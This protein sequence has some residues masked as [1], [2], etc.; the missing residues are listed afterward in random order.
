[1]RSLCLITSR[2]L[3]LQRAAWSQRRNLLTLAIETSCDDTS[4]AVLE[5]HNHKSELH[6]HSRITSDSRAFQGVHPIIALKSHQKNLAALV[7]TA[8]ES[9][10]IQRSAIA[11]LGNT[12]LINHGKGAQ[13][14]RKPDFVTVTR[15]PGMQANLNT[16]LDMAKGLAVAW[17]VPLLGVNHMQAHALTPRLVSSLNAGNDSRGPQPL[18]PFISLLVSGGHTLLVHSRGLC[19]H[20]ILANTIDIA[21]G[22]YIDKCARDVVP[23]SIIERAG[24]VMYGPLLEKFAF[25]GNSE[26]YGYKAPGKR[27]EEIEMRDVGYGWGLTPPLSRTRGGAR[28]N[29]MEFSFSGLGSTVKKVMTSKP[30]VPEIE[31]RMLA[32]EA[33]RVSFEHLALRLLVALQGPEMKTVDTVVVSGGVASNQYLKHI[34]R[35]NLDKKGFENMRL[36]FPPPNLCTDNAAMIAWTGIEMWENGWRS[37]LE[38]S[39]LKK[40]SIDSAAQDGGI[41]EA[42]G[43]ILMGNCLDNA[44][45]ANSARMLEAKW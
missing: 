2:F 1:M 28:D 34:L 27:G 33:M 5:K 22:D 12:L 29:V 36:T 31:R 16:G 37:D 41:L 11:H 14:R 40:W 17:Q 43:W 18:F 44:P 6:F 10:P 24:T 45:H 19:D 20:Q 25:P 23:S 32:R 26:D 4:V 42:G 13:L 21:I 39:T 38:I 7:D 9:L 30:E 35:A 15:G 3:L 8:L